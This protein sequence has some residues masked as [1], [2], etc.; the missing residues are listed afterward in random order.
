MAAAGGFKGQLGSK[1]GRRKNLG[2]VRRGR[3]NLGSKQWVLGM[4]S[5]KVEGRMDLVEEKMVEV[6]GE[7]QREMGSVCSEL[8]CLGPLEKNM[9]VLLEKMGILDRVDRAL[10]RM[11]GSEHP[12]LDSGKARAQEVQIQQPFPQTLDARGSI[13]LEG[14]F[15]VMSTP[16]HSIENQVASDRL[17]ED[18]SQETTT[19]VPPGKKRE[20]ESFRSEGWGR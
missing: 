4:E 6:R 19:E 9:G 3:T 8:Q 10:Q 5:K 18:P 15:E 1:K 20:E 7:L 12:S 13:G 2:F 17:I 11:E 14:G 16:R